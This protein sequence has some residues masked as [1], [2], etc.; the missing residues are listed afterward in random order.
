LPRDIKGF[1]LC[2]RESGC[3]LGGRGSRFK[4]YNK[5]VLPCHFFSA[6]GE[7]A[8]RIVSHNCENKR[9]LQ[10]DQLFTLFVQHPCWKVT[11]RLGAISAITEVMQALC[12]LFRACYISTFSSDSRTFGCARWE[13]RR[14]SRSH[15]ARSGSVQPACLPDLAPRTI[16]SALPEFFHRHLKRRF[17]CLPAPR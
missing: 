17:L 12:A 4:G 7:N 10:T 14:S 8:G 5:L 2:P 15:V 13:P 6:L 3:S 16:L 1:R 11:P 9:R